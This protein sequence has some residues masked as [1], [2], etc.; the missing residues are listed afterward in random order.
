MKTI[1]IYILLIYWSVI[2][3]APIM[4]KD[5]IISENKKLIEIHTS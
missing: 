3:F 2:I 5:N 4:G 1:S